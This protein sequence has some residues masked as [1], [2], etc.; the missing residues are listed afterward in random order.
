[1]AGFIFKAMVWDSPFPNGIDVP[2]WKCSN[3]QLTERRSRYEA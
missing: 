1:M 3:N 2:E